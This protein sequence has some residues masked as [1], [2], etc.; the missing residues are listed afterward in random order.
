MRGLLP[1]L[2]ILVPATEL[3]ILI[4][5]GGHIGAGATLLVIVVTGFAG[6][7]LAK[8]QG[9]EVLRRLQQSMASG[10]EIGTSLMEGALVLAAAV[11][12][13]TPGFVTDIAGF[14]LML[15]W[16]RR[17]LARWIGAR[18]TMQ[19][20]RPAGFGVDPAEPPP[21]FGIDSDEPPPGVIDV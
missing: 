10:L 21:G 18:L 11:A 9:L 4:K 15:P 13:L 5:V 14:L 16:L 3:Y 6:A 1:L 17:G 20:V 7:T 8:R 2:F 12:M 19:V